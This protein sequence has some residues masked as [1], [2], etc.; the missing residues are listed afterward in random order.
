MSGAARQ[1]GIPQWMAQHWYR[2]NAEFRAAVDYA[3]RFSRGRSMLFFLREVRKGS[4]ALAAASH[5]GRSYDWFQKQAQTN[6]G[7]NRLWNLCRERAQE[8]KEP[9]KPDTLYIDAMD[10]KREAQRE[11][12]KSARADVVAADR[13]ALE[14]LYPLVE[15]G[16]L[17]KVAL[18]E[19]GKTVGW[20]SSARDRVP[21]AADRMR[22][23]TRAGRRVRP[24]QP[25][26]DNPELVERDE[27]ARRLVLAAF[28]GGA[29]LMAA[30][31]AGGADAR[32]VAREY[33]RSREFRT[34]VDALVALRPDYDLAA[35]LAILDG[36]NF[37]PAPRPP[38]EA[39]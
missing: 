27:T 29:N 31:K 38:R 35:D 3:R 13:R 15:S 25:R 12:R 33:L 26:R 14:Q 22:Q 1:A 4:P 18:S 16:M 10:R 19:I 17:L 28:A 23:A 37:I 9:T 6:P 24:S 20:L 11:R 21:E 2:Q 30:A 39:K 32:W 34:A 7:F 36:S 8:E 5:S